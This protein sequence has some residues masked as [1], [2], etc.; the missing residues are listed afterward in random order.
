MGGRIEGKKKQR[1]RKKRPP[2]RPILAMS[3]LL[4]RKGADRGWNLLGCILVLAH[5]YHWV[6][7]DLLDLS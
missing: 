3:C 5:V 2:P 4:R 7:A 1:M 6:C